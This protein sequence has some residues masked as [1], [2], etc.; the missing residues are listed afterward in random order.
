MITNITEHCEPLVVDGYR[1]ETIA[2]HD[3]IVAVCA[4]VDVLV[5]DFEFTE[6]E[7]QEA[8]EHI[9]VIATEIH[10]F[11][12]ALFEFFK[13]KADEAGVLLS[14]ASFAREAPAVDDVAIENELFA[15]SVFEE[16]V[17]LVDFTIEGAQV[18]IRENDRFETECCFLHG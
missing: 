9:V 3:E 12:A 1:V 8:G 6:E 10:D 18:H 2:V 5:D 15:M 16:V 7:R 17:H 4:F 11:S 14:P 13:D